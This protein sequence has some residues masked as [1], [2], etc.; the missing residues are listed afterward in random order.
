MGGFDWVDATP[1]KPEGVT[2][3][4]PERYLVEIGDQVR[5]YNPM[6][7]STG[8]FRTF[9]RC[10]TQSSAIR[11]FANRYGR[12]GGPA[13]TAIT[14]AEGDQVSERE[15]LAAWLEQIQGMH[16]AVTLLDAIRANDEEVLRQHIV[17]QSGGR[18]LYTSRHEVA[19]ANFVGKRMKLIASRDLTP[20]LFRRMPK[21]ELKR[22]AWG[23]LQQTIDARLANEVSVRML[24]DLDKPKLFT[25]PKSLIGAMWLQLATD[26]ADD[27]RYELC[28]ACRAS[29]EVGPGAARSHSKYCSNRCKVAGWR[30]D[31][32]KAKRND[33]MKK[34]TSGKLREPS[35]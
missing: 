14:L 25:V 15:P 35:K 6:E 12:L 13:A 4:P 21:G 16:H 5:D 20:A 9:A 1:V 29:F 2:A 8:L 17:W 30:R 22:P 7:S 26:I 24:L 28:Q 23:Y 19:T 11:E 33:G 31:K 18:V 27:K 10:S 32:R 3:E 34:S